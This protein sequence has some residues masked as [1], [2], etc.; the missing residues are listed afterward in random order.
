M[1]ANVQTINLLPT[2]ALKFLFFLN[3][4]YITK[5]IVEEAF[6]RVKK[7]ALYQYYKRY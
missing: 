1:N 3:Y 2:K 6:R 5:N 4:V 7:V